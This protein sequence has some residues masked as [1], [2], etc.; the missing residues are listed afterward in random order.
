MQVSRK[1]NWGVRHTTY[2]RVPVW[3]NKASKPLAVKSVG[4]KVAGKTPSL[5]EEFVGETHRVLECIQPHPP[6]NQ[7]Q[8]GPICLWAVREV[9]ESQPRAEKAALFPLGPLPQGQ[10]HNTAVWVA[11]PWRIPK[12]LP[13]KT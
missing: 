9:T 4:V 3:E 12:A 5:T 1:N 2:L 11:P 6:G 10:H 7:H 13:L 8:K